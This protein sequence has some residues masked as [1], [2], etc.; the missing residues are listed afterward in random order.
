MIEDKTIIEVEQGEITFLSLKSKSGLNLLHG[1]T[2]EQ[3]YSSLEKIQSNANLKV[4]IIQGQG[5]KCFQQ[6]QILKNYW[7]QI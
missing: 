5:T 4:L 2:L 7:I 3:L 1:Q 6:E